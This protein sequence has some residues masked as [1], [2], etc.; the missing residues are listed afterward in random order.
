MVLKLVMII[1]M[2]LLLLLL[3]LRVMNLTPPLFA[4]QNDI[5]KLLSHDHQ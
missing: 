4:T 5:M 2:M 1:I 3:L